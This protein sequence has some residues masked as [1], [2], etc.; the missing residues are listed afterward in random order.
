MRAVSLASGVVAG[1]VGAGAADG[2]E[3]TMGAEA[4]PAVPMGRGTGVLAAGGKGGGANV[5]GLG[6]GT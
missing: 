6:N 2:R 5:G 4:A 1:V 3:V